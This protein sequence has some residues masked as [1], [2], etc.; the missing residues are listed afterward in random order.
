MSEVY[1]GNIGSSVKSPE[2]DRGEQGN[3][4]VCATVKDL[5]LLPHNAPGMLGKTRCAGSAK[6]SLH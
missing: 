6:L 3:Y 1:R 2:G 4:V 5:S